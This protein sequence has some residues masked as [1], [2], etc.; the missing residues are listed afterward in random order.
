MK[1]KRA[2]IS[3]TDKTGLLPLAQ[4]LEK[5]G[6][7]II[8]SGGT[9]KFLQE[10]NIAVTE[11]SKI[12]GNPE[13]F[14]GRMKTI[15]F[16]VES[17]ILFDRE[18]DK[19]EAEALDIEPIDLVV[20]NLYQYEKYV[21]QNS[22]YDSL[23]EN[24]DIGGQTMIR[25]AAKNFKY[26]TVLCNPDDYPDVINELKINDGGISYNT[27]KKLMASAFNYT[28]DYESGI[29]M[30]FDKLNGDESIRLLFNK[31]KELRYG[32]NPHQNAMVFRENKT[33]NSLFDIEV[34]NG[35]E[36]SYNNM[37]DI[38]A[39]IEAVIG[40]G[41]KMCAIIKHNNPCGL[42]WGEDAV[43][44]LNLA[45]NGDNI[46]AFG[47]IA[48]FNFK[49]DYQT[50]SFFNFEA[51]EKQDR[52]FIEII[53][54]PEFS[55]EALQ[56]FNKQKKLRVIQFNPEL[57]K[58]KNDLKYVNGALL[59]QTK[60]DKLYEK[61]ELVTKTFFD[62]KSKIDLISFG[63]NAV[64]HVKSNA[65]VTVREMNGYYQLLGIGAGQPNRLNSISLALEKTAANLRAEGIKN[66]GNV[67][68]VSDA[69]LPFEDNVELTSKYGIKVIVQPGGS[70]RDSKVIDKCNQLGISMI[71]TGTRHFKH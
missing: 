27:R 36:L 64:R 22:G 44:V 3:V 24:I 10:H 53:A 57:V 12:T 11:I 50:V 16:Q 14:S 60:D 65:I 70:I 8:S 18:R 7:E 66:M 37:L 38:N 13:A 2:L 26:V 28:A 23:I 33:N 51:P 71:F 5:S 39:G 62:Y 30:A 4:L 61:L 19:I 35:I 6:C 49:V 42:A 54:A 21:N 25:A 58:N 34:L 47:G 46:S 52:K 41:S 31:G 20:C 68:L 59:I 40:L 43:K 63:L 32:E 69:F 48:A 67:M 15:S 9:A 29:A 17:A 55:D 56:Y 45:W 1:I